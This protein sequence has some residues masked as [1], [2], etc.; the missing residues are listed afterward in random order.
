MTGAFERFM[1]S[2]VDADVLVFAES[3]AAIYEVEARVLAD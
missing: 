1:Q 3:Y 2:C